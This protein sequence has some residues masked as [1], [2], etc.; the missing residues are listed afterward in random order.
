[1]FLHRTLSLYDTTREGTRVRVLAQPRERRGPLRAPP[2]W[3]GTLQGNVTW[4]NTLGPR[5]NHGTSP[6]GDCDK[7]LVSIRRKPMEAVVHPR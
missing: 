1:M 2:S 6:V 4:Y 3:C 7:R 5:H